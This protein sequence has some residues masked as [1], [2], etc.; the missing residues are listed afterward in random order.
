MW[1][2]Y[3]ENPAGHRTG[4]CTV[5]AISVALGVDWDTAFE[6]LVTRAFQ[7]KAMPSTDAVWGAVLRSAGFFRRGP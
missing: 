3:N 1:I 5:R 6:M 4:D 2:E 7:M